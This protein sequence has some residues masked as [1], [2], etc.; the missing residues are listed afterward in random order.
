MKKWVCESSD[1]EN[2]EGTG[3]K[4]RRERRESKM[5]TRI[6]KADIKSSLVSTIKAIPKMFA[7]ATLAWVILMVF[8][9]GWIPLPFGNEVMQGRYHFCSEPVH[10]SVYINTENVSDRYVD[11]YKND[12][13]TALRWWEEKSESKIGCGFNYTIVSSKDAETITVLWLPKL[14]NED[15]VEGYWN[16]ATKTVELKLGLTDVDTIINARH[17]FGHMLGLRESIIPGDVTYCWGRVVV[18]IFWFLVLFVIAE[19]H[20][21]MIMPAGKLILERLKKKK[22]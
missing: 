18:A 1:G 14:R 6:T 9:V 21:L 13:I 20:I 22:T 5:K 16:Y 7:L 17:E 19:I 12:I 10:K 8:I 11:S 15:G 2:K 4:G 3:W